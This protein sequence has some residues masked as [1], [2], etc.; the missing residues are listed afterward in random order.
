MPSRKRK[1]EM[2]LPQEVMTSAQPDQPADAEQ[3][4]KNKWTEEQK[5]NQREMYEQQGYIPTHT[6]CSAV[7]YLIGVKESN[8]LPDDELVWMKQSVF[9]ELSQDR[10]CR[11]VRKLCMIRMTVKLSFSRACQAVQESNFKGFLREFM[12]S[13]DVFQELYK[14]GCELP[15]PGRDMNDFLLAVDRRIGENFEKLCHL[16]QFAGVEFRYLK[17]VMQFPGGIKKDALRNL[18]YDAE[19]RGSYPFGCYINLDLAQ[20][21]GNIL[22]QDDDFVEMLYKQ[23][24]GA[25][26]DIS[27]YRLSYGASGQDKLKK[28][29]RPDGN[30]QYLLYIDGAGIRVPA[31]RQVLAVIRSINS[32]QLGSCVLYCP[33][34]KASEWKQRLG[35]ECDRLELCEPQEQF[36]SQSWTDRVAA[37]I[38]IRRSRSSENA[39]TAFVFIA[40]SDELID[41][42]CIS[43]ILERKPFFTIL[44]QQPTDL[45]LRRLNS[46]TD[47]G[48]LEDIVRELPD[49]TALQRKN[50]EDMAW[51][52]LKHV[53]PLDLKCDLQKIIAE[54]LLPLP[55]DYPL[56]EQRAYLEAL[57]KAIR[58]EITE[59]GQLWAVF[60]PDAMS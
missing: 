10:I 4:R 19:S 29:M 41:Q 54:K 36:A 57:R 35:E 23:N 20:T 9:D 2:P 58:L 30:Y 13:A 11:V 16:P 32:D 24:G 14:D 37:D 33:H 7:G 59:E 39:N 31:L 47:Y 3:G 45:L 44:L 26:P 28:F 5:K 6:L 43:G 52:E 22:K 40:P 8:F 12:E 46:K 53:F 34:E 18:P 55:E 42:L 48:L 50:K 51:K 38:G 49:E 56:E 1:K 15:P 60:D 27:H 21:V 17:K 25:V